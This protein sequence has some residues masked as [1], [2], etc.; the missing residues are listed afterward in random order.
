MKSSL[1]SLSCVLKPNSRFNLI[2]Y[3]LH[4]L[5][6]SISIH[7]KWIG[8]KVN[9]IQSDCHTR[10]LY[11][12][13][14]WMMYK[15]LFNNLFIRLLQHRGS[16][17]TSTTSSKLCHANLNPSEQNWSTGGLQIC[18]G[19]DESFSWFANQIRYFLWYIIISCY[20]RCF[21]FN[22]SFSTTSC[23]LWLRVKIES[24]GAEL[25]K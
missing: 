12:S 17:P 8:S 21:L 9:L 2:L 11:L 24:G 15:I 20:D 14:I 18:L 10:V 3:F 5:W 4:R 22:I 23:K 1:Y 7:L 25:E 16:S 13:I 6:D 19:L